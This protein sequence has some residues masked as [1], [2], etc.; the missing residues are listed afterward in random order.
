VDESDTGSTHFVVLSQDGG[1]LP[2]GFRGCA[3]SARQAKGQDLSDGPARAAQP[4]RREGALCHYN[5]A[6][7]AAC[8]AHGHLSEVVDFVWS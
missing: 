6:H 3:V 1:E 2:T 8:M 4:A 5:A 7:T